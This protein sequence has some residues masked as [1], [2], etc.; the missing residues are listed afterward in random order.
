MRVVVALGG[1]ALSRR[2]GGVT[3]EGMRETALAA[4][5]EIAAAFPDDGLVIT[6]GNGPQVGL[7][8]LQSEALRGSPPTPLDVLGAESEGMI[9]SLLE[10]ALSRVMPRRQ[11]AVLLT[12]VVVDRDDPSFARPTKPIGPIYPEEV[13]RRLAAERGWTLGADRD[14]VRRLVASPEPR[15]VRATHAIRALLEAGTVV[16]AAGGGGVPV[17]AAGAGV[18]GVPAVIDKDLTAALLAT[19]IGADLLVILTDVPGVY[20]SWPSRADLLARLTPASHPALRERGYAPG[21]MGPKI[22]AACRFVE[23]TGRPAVIGALGE[24]VAIVRGDAGT[25]V[26]RE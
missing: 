17:V 6:H 4:A 14:G 3:V 21:S 9:G 20:A 26:E 8:A 22:E 25:R 13:G 16:V 18:R 10:E 5:S 15:A 24:L 23:R 19:E 2:G 11:T 1:N 7:L 12:Q